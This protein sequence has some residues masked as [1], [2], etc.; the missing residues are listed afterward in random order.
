MY[1]SKNIKKQKS[2]QQ[3]IAA[4]RNGKATDKELIIRTVNGEHSVPIYT[5][6]T[7]LSPALRDLFFLCSDS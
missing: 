5:C 2:A 1:G 6:T 3:V 4:E 7:I